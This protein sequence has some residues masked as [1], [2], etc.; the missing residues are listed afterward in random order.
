MAVAQVNGI[1]VRG[2]ASAVPRCARTVEDDALVF[3]RDQA[4][5]VSKM[6]GVRA[7]RVVQGGTI[8]SDL[9]YRA[10]SDLL[11]ELDWAPNSI[12]ALI[13][14]TQYPDYVCPATACTLQERL[15]L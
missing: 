15:G 13:L 9:C 6:T 11:R 3:G 5:K 4:Q 14:V 1:R 2:V 8:T 10:A 7:R 12:E